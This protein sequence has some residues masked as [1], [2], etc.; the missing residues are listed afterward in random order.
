MFVYQKVGMLCYLVT[1]VLRFAFFPYCRQIITHEI[2]RV[3]KTKLKTNF[4]VN[5]I[6][7]NGD[8]Y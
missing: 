4:L 7:E 3:T 8:Q 1:S 5:S 6:D 2:T